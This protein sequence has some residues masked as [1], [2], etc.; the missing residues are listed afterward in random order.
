MWTKALDGLLTHFFKS[1][2]LRVT[3]PDGITRTYGAGGDCVAVTSCS[4][5]T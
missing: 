4:H 2:C 3:Y 5:L 1:G